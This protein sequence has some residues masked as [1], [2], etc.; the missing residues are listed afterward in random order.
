MLLRAGVCSAG[1]NS[2]VV[3]AALWAGTSRS[4]C[5]GE[6]GCFLAAR[7]LPAAAALGAACGA[8]VRCRYGGGSAFAACSSSECGRPDEALICSGT[9]PDPP[10]G[11][12]AHHRGE[13]DATGALLIA[14]RAAMVMAKQP[15]R[16]DLGRAP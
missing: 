16:N 14:A 12:A 4:S 7:R 6:N 11:A 2:R 8:W 15:D 1:S 13:P 3:V 9:R 10:S 5:R